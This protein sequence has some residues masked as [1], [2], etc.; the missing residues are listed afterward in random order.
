VCGLRRQPEEESR[1]ASNGILWGHPGGHF[2]PRVPGHL[3]LSGASFLSHMWLAALAAMVVTALVIAVVEHKALRVRA[4]DLSRGDRPVLGLG[5]VAILAAALLVGVL[6]SPSLPVLAVG[7][8]AIGARLVGGRD[9]P[10]HVVGVLGLPVL[11]GLFGVAVALGTLGRVWSGP[12]TL[13]SHLDLW[14]TAVV[15]AGS[16]VLVNNLPAASH[17]WADSL[18]SGDVTSSGPPLQP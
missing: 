18:G 1:V 15:A 12:A 6:R 17:P 4:D 13:L 9:H 5:L 16:S 2:R 10:R 7:V 11:V 8:V 3:H 14:G